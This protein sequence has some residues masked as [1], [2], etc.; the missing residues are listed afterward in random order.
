[1]QRRESL[2][3]LIVSGGLTLLLRLFV[4]TLNVFL[5]KA[6]TRITICGVS[7]SCVPWR[8]HKQCIGITE[9]PPQPPPAG[10]P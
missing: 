8:V 10:G 7:P 9:E 4:G 3:L 1:M 2:I 5:E 6:Q